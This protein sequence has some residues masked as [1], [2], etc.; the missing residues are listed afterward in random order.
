MSFSTLKLYIFVTILT[1]ILANTL[2][3]KRQESVQFD[4]KLVEKS[5]VYVST[6]SIKNDVQNHPVVTVFKSTVEE[7]VINNTET[8]YTPNATQ[9][10]P[11]KEPLLYTF[12][13][14]DTRFGISKSHFAQKVSEA[15]ALWSNAAGKQ[16]F[17]QGEPND[18]NVITIDLVYDG[19]QAKTDQN[20]LLG[21]E[22]ENSKLAAEKLKTEYEALGETFLVM[23]DAYTSDV[24]TFN[25]R[26]KLYND[27]VTS[28]NEK[29]GAP[30]KEYDI[31][32]LEK[33]ALALE[34][35]KLNKTQNDLNSFLATINKK[36]TRYNELVTFANQKI[37]ENNTLA[38]GKFTE[39]SYTYPP[40]KITIYQFS[41][42]IKL[43][44]VLAHE[45]GHA[46]SI[47]HTKDKSSIMYSVNNATTTKLSAE[48][49]QE[50]NDLCGQ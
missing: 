40:R 34:M 46:L 24:A 10:N 14:F 50:I 33:D 22:I 27:T 1:L 4:Q 25:E 29:G 38:K 3:Q 7:V 26:Q 28:W 12:G 43:L 42:D 15:T 18:N 21:L 2:I 13:S 17:M 16:L 41:D 19:R 31:L 5:E 39:G 48:D 36:I 11:C 20:K 49:I 37:G 44:R 32:A 35:E 6:S 30:K 23:K 45:F 8:D 47:D 9:I